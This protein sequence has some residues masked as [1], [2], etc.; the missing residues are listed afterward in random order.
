MEITLKTLRICLYVSAGLGILILLIGYLDTIINPYSE[1]L[2]DARRFIFMHIE[3]ENILGLFILLNMVI[4]L[5]LTI[6]LKKMRKNIA[7]YIAVIIGIIFFCLYDSL[8][9]Y[10]RPY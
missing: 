10:L 3:F 2:N 7:N 6:V 8:S 5:S 4:V 9:G 1:N